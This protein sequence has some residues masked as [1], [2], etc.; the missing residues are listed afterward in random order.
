MPNMEPLSGSDDHHLSAA[1]RGLNKNN[2]ALPKFEQSREL[3]KASQTDPLW[4]SWLQKVPPGQQ[5]GDTEGLAG[6]RERKQGDLQFQT[7]SELAQV[8]S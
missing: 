8:A 6:D 4:S 1:A 7:A 3:L 2:V 5:G